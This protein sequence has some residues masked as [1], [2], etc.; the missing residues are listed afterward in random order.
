[1]C[2]VLALLLS[3]KLLIDDD[4]IKYHGFGFLFHRFSAEASNSFS[5]SLRALLLF[6]KPDEFR[7]SI[8]FGQNL[9]VLYVS[10]VNK[11]KNMVS[12]LRQCKRVA[13]PL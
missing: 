2:F 7:E 1:M 12:G 6:R 10:R 4:E 3:A 11:H 13:F 8:A 9:F 5:V